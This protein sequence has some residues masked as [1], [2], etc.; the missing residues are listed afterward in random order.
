MNEIFSFKRFFLLIRK[1]F[2]E[3]SRLYFMSAVVLAGVFVFLFGMKI[4]SGFDQG[5]QKSIMQIGLIMGGAVFSS[6]VFQDMSDRAH[7]ILSL[8]LPASHLEK[9]LCAWF[10]GVILFLPAYFLIFYSIDIAAVRIANTYSGVSSR[11][12]PPDNPF[13]GNIL[14][15]FFVTQSVAMLGSI[16]FKRRQFVQTAFLAFV[17][18]FILLR[19]DN[20]LAGWLVP[21]DHPSGGVILGGIWFSQQ[22]SVTFLPIPAKT[23]RFIEQIFYL[24]PLLFWLTAFFKLREKQL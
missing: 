19:L 10:Y 21:V 20:L 24:L 4:G 22:G 5:F 6:L 1:Q 3:Q 14:S 8:T 7:G 11:V 23:L 16:V 15:I 18:I 12:L 9:F 17:I 2:I 13:M